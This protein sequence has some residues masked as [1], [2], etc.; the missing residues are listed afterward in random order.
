[1][2]NFEIRNVVQSDCGQYRCYAFNKFSSDNSIAELKIESK[3]TIDDANDTDQ[4]NVALIA[5]NDSVG[6][7]DSFTRVSHFISSKQQFSREIVS[8]S[9]Y[10]IP[11]LNLPRSN[12]N[13]IFRNIRKSLLGALV[14]IFSVFFLSYYLHISFSLNESDCAENLLDLSEY[15]FRCSDSYLNQ[16]DNSN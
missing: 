6:K 13:F 9:N 2:I 7:T 3:N 14:A 5:K 1:M 15:V 10:S 8:D 4:C 12:I 11:S 16:I